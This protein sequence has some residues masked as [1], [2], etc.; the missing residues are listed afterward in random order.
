[1]NMQ[2][3][4]LQKP[5]VSIIIPTYNRAHLIGQTLDSLLA[6]TYT[7][8]ECIIVDDGS[9][10]NTKEIIYNYCIKDCRFKYYSR[11]IN[12]L[13][14]PSSCRNFGFEQSKGDYIQWFDSDDLYFFNSLEIYVNHVSKNIDA[15]VA[16]LEKIDFKSG[17]KRNE[18]NIISKNIIEDYFTEKISFYVCG[19]LWSRYFL[20][21]QPMLFDEAIRNL[22][23]W[24]F[25]L[26]MLYQ[27]PKMIYI[28]KPLIQYRLHD[29]SLSKEIY[30][31]N[32]DE[33]KS[34]FFAF[35]KHLK[36]IKKNNSADLLIVN[37]FY[38]DRCKFILREALVKNSKAKF[39][40]FKKLLREQLKLYDFSGMF[41][42]TI[43]YVLFL[44]FSRGYFFFK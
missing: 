35:E 11:P 43:G 40:L 3:R 37:T 15:V 1:M 4:N 21:Q 9:I 39:F 38:K 16:K 19:A 23:D 8:W 31:L 6:Q 26:T 41:K 24:D 30:K 28:E 44:F 42:T 5:L 33:L 25:N 13:S 36:L 20:E 7:N 32:L 29:D 14:G 34:K 22:D 2:I 10:D 27:N 12:K 18:N 17:V